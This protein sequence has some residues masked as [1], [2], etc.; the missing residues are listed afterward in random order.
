[1]VDNPDY[2][3]EN[4]LAELLKTGAVGGLREIVEVQLNDNVISSTDSSGNTFRKVDG[5]G[6]V[7]YVKPVESN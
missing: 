3:L 4:N 5:K 7:T 2:Q 6:N 1:V